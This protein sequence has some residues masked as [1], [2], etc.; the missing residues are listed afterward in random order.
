MNSCAYTPAF[1]LVKLSF[2]LSCLKWYYLRWF[3]TASQPSVSSSPPVGCTIMVFILLNWRK[4]ETSTSDVQLSVEFV[5]N[6]LCVSG[7]S[8][9]KLFLSRHIKARRLAVL[10]HCFSDIGHFA[11][12]TLILL[13]HPQGELRY[14]QTFQRSFGVI[15]LGSCLFAVDTIPLKNIS[16]GRVDFLKRS[17][18]PM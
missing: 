8:R 5:V 10:F 3:K 14:S 15:I 6:V 1:S 17:C 16:Y 18:R 13:K 12:T 2:Y 4:T 7:Q 11:S 9:V